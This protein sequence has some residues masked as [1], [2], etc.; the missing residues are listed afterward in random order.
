[1][2]VAEY[3]AVTV[4][5]ARVRRVVPQVAV[6]KHL[7]DIGHAHWG[8]RVAGFGLLD[9]IDGQHADGICHLPRMFGRWLVHFD[10]L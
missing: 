9:R 5:P 7:G 10:A 1:M 2:A 8:A 3:K 6:P 4:G